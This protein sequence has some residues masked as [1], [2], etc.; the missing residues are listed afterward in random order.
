MTSPQVRTRPAN[1]RDQILSAA[2]ELFVDRTYSAVSMSMI[3]DEVG[4]RPSA[5][6]RHFANKEAV[7]GEAFDGYVGRLCRALDEA[8]SD[9]PIDALAA[10]VLR[11][12]Y[13][14]RLWIRECRHLPGESVR[15][16]QGEL[17]SRLDAVVRQS[18]SGQSVP[19]QSVSGQS[20]SDQSVSGPAVR[21]R[22][23]AVLGVL[24][25]TATHH[26]ELPGPQLLAALARRAAG[27]DR[28]FPP[29]GSPT[30]GLG[31]AGTR[32]QILAA[33]VTLFA[34]RTYDGV[35]I[36]HLAEAVGLAP[37]SIYNHFSGK[38]E[39]LAVLL[40]RGNGYLQITLDDVLSR[41]T[42]T[43]SALAAASAGY[44]AFAVRHPAMVHAIVT[45]AGGLDEPDATLLRAAQRQYVAEWVRLCLGDSPET[46]P[47]PEAAARITV[48]AAITAINDLARLPDLP[49][50]SAAEDFV[51]AYGHVILAAGVSADESC[52]GV[53]SET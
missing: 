14:G 53:P 30:A 37:S 35:G 2:T 20:V 41:A 21:A 11:D 47:G 49:R 16:R 45:E 4:V 6:Y 42:D 27:V 7:L 12:R 40:H 48:L 8:G 46:G 38:A 24:L 26:A 29:A 52:A 15:E 33:A 23:T 50:T 5:L 51:A 13:T 18:D 39:I 19:D 31:R 1:R 43:R 28:P 22:S 17:L 10:Q 9:D 25:S 34:E 32:E 3:A 36:D 44:A